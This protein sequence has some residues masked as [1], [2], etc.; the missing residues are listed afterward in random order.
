MYTQGKET[1][2]FPPIYALVIVSNEDPCSSVISRKI[3]RGPPICKESE[4]L[5]RKRYGDVVY[6]LSPKNTIWN[7]HGKLCADMGGME[8]MPK[9]P[10]LY[11]FFQ[12][13]L[14]DAGK[15]GYN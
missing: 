10:E 3:L 15:K 9:T 6:Y 11:Q 1:V 2:L 12:A 8:G 5:N 14:R 7:K 4:D 13:M